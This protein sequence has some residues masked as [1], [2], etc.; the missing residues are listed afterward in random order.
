MSSTL[1]GYL[2]GL[3]AF[4]YLTYWFG[5]KNP[6]IAA[7]ALGTGVI[8]YFISFIT[9][10][11]I[12]GLGIGKASAISHMYFA[13]IPTEA[14]VFE[15]KVG[16]V[17]ILTKG[18]DIDLTTDLYK[19]SVAQQLLFSLKKYMDCNKFNPTATAGA[20]PQKLN[21]K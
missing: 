15:A 18:I 2:I 11:L 10:S 9:Y 20:Y 13:K 16:K 14:L 5:R 17:K 8:N 21:S 7:A 1:I 4:G 3:L 19:R 12:G 6:L